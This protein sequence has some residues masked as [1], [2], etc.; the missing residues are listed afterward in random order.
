MKVT[1]KITGEDVTKY[2]I[3]LLEGL[4]TQDEFE[5]LTMVTK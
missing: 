4:I 1:N 3:G 5:E 2:F